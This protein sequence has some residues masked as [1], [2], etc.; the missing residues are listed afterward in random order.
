MVDAADVDAAL[1]FGVLSIPQFMLIHWHVIW[2][3]TIWQVVPSRQY[4]PLEQQMAV[5]GMQLYMPQ[6]NELTQ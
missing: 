1:L 3:S 4:W 6:Q 5:E 2:S